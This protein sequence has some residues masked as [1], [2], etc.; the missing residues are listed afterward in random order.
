VL[1][2]LGNNVYLLE[3]PQELNIGSIFNVKDLIKYYGTDED[4]NPGQPIPILPKVQHAREDI[5]DILDEQG[6]GVIRNFLSRRKENQFQ[7]AF[8]LLL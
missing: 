6:M 3:L 5:E 1:K 7:K 4:K 2:C 8:G